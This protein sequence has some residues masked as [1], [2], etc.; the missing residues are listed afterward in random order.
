MA[1][2][3]NED[4][5]NSTPNMLFDLRQTYA[6]HL[7]TPILLELRTYRREES[8]I[9]WFE[10][11]TEDLYVEVNQKLSPGEREDY[12]ELY[13]KTIAVLREFANAYRGT[14]K[15]PERKAR[16][17]QALM[18]LEMWLKN[19]MEEKGLYGKGSEYDWDE[20]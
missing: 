18:Q 11:I 12:S 14:D 3:N 4:F 5:M 7:L 15:T 9:K 10:T 17:K 2:N 13:N 19:K 16:V 20:I 1:R 6:I 8:F